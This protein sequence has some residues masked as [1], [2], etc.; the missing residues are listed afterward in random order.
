MLSFLR[1]Y[2]DQFVVV[3]I[4]LTPVPREGYRIGVPAE[5]EYQ[6]IFNSDSSYY[7]GS[8][9][10]NGGRALITEQLSWMNQ[11]QSLS[12]TLPPLAAIV[13]KLK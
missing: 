1:R 9:L 2:E 3:V 10:G 8:N 11:P 4:N 6:E 5:G 12:L 7:G 13:L